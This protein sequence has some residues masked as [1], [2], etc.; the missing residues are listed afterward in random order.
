LGIRSSITN[1]IRIAR[2]LLGAALSFIIATNSLLVSAASLQQDGPSI[3]EPI[4]QLV[5]KAHGLKAVEVHSLMQQNSVP[6]HPIQETYTSDRYWFSLNIEAYPEPW[7]MNIV[8]RSLSFLEIH[9][10]HNGTWQ[11]LECQ[12]LSLSS[13]PR[14]IMP[15]LLEKTQFLIAL[16]FSNTAS[17]ELHADPIPPPP[18]GLGDAGLLLN[19]FMVCVGFGLIIFLGIFSWSFRDVNYILFALYA[20]TGLAYT[21]IGIGIVH[22]LRWPLLWNIALSWLGC[23]SV[24]FATLFARNHLQSKLMTPLQRQLFPLIL[25]LTLAQ[26]VINGL[27]PYPLFNLGYTPEIMS[28]F[29]MI[30][31]IWTGFTIRSESRKDVNYFL[32]AWGVFAFFSILLLSRQYGVWQSESIFAKS[33]LRIGTISLLTILALSV[34]K[35]AQLERKHLLDT[36]ESTNDR[37]EGE[38]KI[39]TQEILD[40]Q[41]TL[42]HTAKMASVGELTGGIAHEINNP[43]AIISGLSY[44]MQSEARHDRLTPDR[45]RYY[46]LR[47]QTAVERIAVIVKH[48]QILSI[49]DHYS[50]DN[51]IDLTE[52][53]DNFRALIAERFRSHG[54][55]LRVPETI[56]ALHILGSK[57]SIGQILLNLSNNALDAIARSSEP[58]VELS[59]SETRDHICFHVTD[60]GS[61]IASDVVQKMFDP[62]FT[63]KEVGKGTGLGLS[64]SRKIAESMGGT[65][66]YSLF[67]GHTRFSLT[68]KVSRIQQPLSA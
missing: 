46:H 14:C 19:L 17:L 3:K 37:L 7:V 1:S 5:D 31:A 11:K 39:R 67:Q 20:L 36:L 35:R 57:G 64:I 48:L 55:E 49:S 28:L 40:Q 10:M 16:E 30:V 62:F 61:G 50:D 21:A 29:V 26:M 6:F 45:V 24:L 38:V 27:S 47:M 34:A 43:L 25:I 52:L 56:P 2:H 8:N 9:Q 53:V 54:I 44:S 12:S 68:L 59:L 41:Q 33:L 15:P 60:S 13:H 4:K 58:W 66:T 32:A 63:T 42:I 65:L 22:M 18:R 51:S 23:A